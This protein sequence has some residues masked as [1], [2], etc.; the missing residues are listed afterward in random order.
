MRNSELKFFQNMLLERQ[1]QIKKNIEDAAKSI[2]SLKDNEV[3]DEAD[4]AAVTTERMIDH[5]IT[6]K[7]TKELAEI[8]FTL[9]KMSSGGYGVCDMCEE[10]IGI[11]RLK[12]KPH[13]KYCIVCR[14][15]V[16]KQ[17]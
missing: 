17:N 14:E 5:A 2:T 8:N 6:T 13:A 10:D 15:I 3:G 9:A 4:H 1:V 11:Q 7:Q 12:V 16:E